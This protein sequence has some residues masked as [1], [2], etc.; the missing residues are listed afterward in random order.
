M[1]GVE[2]CIKP[3][4]QVK[5]LVILSKNVQNTHNKKGDFMTRYLSTVYFEGVDNKVVTRKYVEEVD[6]SVGGTGSLF[7]T[8]ALAHHNQLITALRAVSDAGI[9]FS[10][11]ALELPDTTPEAP[12]GKVYEKALLIVR[13]VDPANPDKTDDIDFPAPN[14]GV[15][16]G[17]TGKDANRIDVNDVAIGDLMDAFQFFLW[18]DGETIDSSAGVNGLEE[19]Y[20]VL[21]TLRIPH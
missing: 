8:V 20:R 7:V 21:S 12:G 15:F 11:I 6:E 17:T 3:Q 1:G 5:S 2:T 13:L 10:T 18:S 9:N 14:P 16:I 19:G 4:K